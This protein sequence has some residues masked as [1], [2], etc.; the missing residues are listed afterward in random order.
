M[1]IAILGVGHLGE[2]VLIGLLDSGMPPAQ[3][4]ATA[5]PAERAAVLADAYGIEVGTDNPSAVAEA[6]VVLLAVRP[7][8]VDG[9]LAEI[10]P[11]LEPDAVVV[12]LA[13]GVKLAAIQDRLPEG[14]TVVRAMTNVAARAREAAT[15]LTAPEGTDLT[16]IEDLFD[17]V[18]VTV[19]VEE[20]MMDLVT[21]VAGSGPAFLFYLADA[22]TT[23]AVEG[24]MDRAAARVMVD[25]MLLGAC[26]HLQ[27][28]DEP[29]AELLEGVDTPGGT[30]A[31][32][33]DVLN[34]A[35]VDDTVK[36][37][38]VAAARRGRDLARLSPVPAQEQ[39]TDRRHRD[40]DRGDEHDHIG[41]LEARGER[42]VGDRRERGVPCLRDEPLAAHPQRDERRP[43]QDRRQDPDDERRDPPPR[44]HHHRHDQ[45]PQGDPREPGRGP[46][47]LLGA[48]L[49]LGDL[50]RVEQHVLGLDR[51]DVGGV[52][53]VVLRQPLLD[54]LDHPAQVERERV[55]LGPERS[56]VLAFERRHE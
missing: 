24:G 53:E 42:V 18:G 19:V 25:Q 54:D 15:A 16:E 17:R 55:P 4:W 31:A 8:A 47:Q 14:V 29:A 5:L 39:R 13:A 36:R 21:A 22:M 50:R 3:I 45:E 48:L 6:D 11:V 10:A 44:R 2:A 38:V 28:S 20:P 9:V 51:G 41:A 46:L 12:S 34:G 33:L 52:R 43:R 26:L 30:T 40:H 23:A 49:E 1:D 32:A 35:A 37:A 7:G 27:S 56:G